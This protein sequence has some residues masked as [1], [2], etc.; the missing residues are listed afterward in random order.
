MQYFE[1]N[2]L[3]AIFWM[4]Y[5][6]C[7]ILNALFRV[8]Y[9]ECNILSAIFWMRYFL[10]GVCVQYLEC[11]ILNAI[12][13]EQYFIDILWSIFCNVV[14]VYK[15]KHISHYKYSK[16][17]ISHMVSN[18]NCPKGHIGARQESAGRI[19]PQRGV[20]GQHNFFWH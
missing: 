10:W 11:N 17:F 20:C 16:C 6:E 14:P 13:W 15:Q 7:N 5:F 8:Q 9:L 19:R 18:S 2:I 4:Q 1:C 12:F 3:S